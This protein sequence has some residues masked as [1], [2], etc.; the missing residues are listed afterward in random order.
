MRKTEKRK[1]SEQRGR[2]LFVRGKASYKKSRHV[3]RKL[4]LDET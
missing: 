3:A 1:Q 4:R 2:E